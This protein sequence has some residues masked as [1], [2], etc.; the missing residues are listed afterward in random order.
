PRCLAMFQSVTI[1]RPFGIRTSI[2]WSFWL[3]PAFI[4]ISGYASGGLPMAVI[5]TFV[6]L[7]I[8]GCVALHKLGHALAARQFGVRTRDIMLYPIGGVASLERIPRSPGAEIAIALAGP[9]VNV[10]IVALLLPL[11]RLDGYQLTG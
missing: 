2:H 1:G 11:M 3:L 4:L 5:D 9:A 8:F 7:A 6:V 10:A